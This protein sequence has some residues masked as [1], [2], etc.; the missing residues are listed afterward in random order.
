MGN[1]ISSSLWII[2]QSIPE[3]HFFDRFKI[4]L[5]TP[6]PPKNADFDQQKN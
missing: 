1:F 6:P 3:G 4:V 2:F 5:P